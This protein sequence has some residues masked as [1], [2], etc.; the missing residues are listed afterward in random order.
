M[1]HTTKS[2]NRPAGPPMGRA[3]WGTPFLAQLNGKQFDAIARALEQR[4]TAGGAPVTVVAR[5][6]QIVR[7]LGRT[8]WLATLRMQDVDF[9][10]SSVLPADKNPSTKSGICN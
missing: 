8:G 2:K 6:A 1:M 10:K 7:A 9:A 5:M 3:K 4:L